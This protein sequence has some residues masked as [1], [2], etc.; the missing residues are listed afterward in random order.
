[1]AL[2]ALVLLLALLSTLSLPQRL[3]FQVKFQQVM[4]VWLIVGLVVIF[5]HKYIST[6]AFV[7]LLPPIAY[8]SEYF[9]TSN[10]KR[11]ILNLFFFLVLG[12]SVLLRYRQLLG[13]NRFLQIND[14]GLLLPEQPPVSIK[15]QK[16]LVLGDDIS[17]YRQNRPTTPYLNWQLAQRHFGYLNEYLPVYEIYQNFQKE[18]PTYIIDKAGLM[19]KLK[20]RLP[21]VFDKYRPTG[22]AGVYKAT[23]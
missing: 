3:V 22:E 5:T 19:P 14:S 17:Y 12:G 2:P 16:V 10:R 21:A 18:T 6:S 20:Y 15:N 13:I 11:W 4:W 7:L 9:F 23:R 1:M 8:F